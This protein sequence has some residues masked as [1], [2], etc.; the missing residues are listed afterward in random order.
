MDIFKGA[1]TVVLVNHLICVSNLNLENQKLS[2]D[3]RFK[4]ENEVENKLN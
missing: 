4:T 2:V 1:K 3:V